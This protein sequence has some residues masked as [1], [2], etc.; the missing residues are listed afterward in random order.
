MEFRPFRELPPLSCVVSRNRTAV[1]E[2]QKS[3]A[4]RGF[5]AGAP[6]FTTALL[7][8][9]TKIERPKP[10]RSRPQRGGFPARRAPWPAL[11]LKPAHRAHT[12]PTTRSQLGQ[13]GGL[14]WL[15]C[16]RQIPGPEI[17]Q[18][19]AVLFQAV[20]IH[21]LRQRGPL[22]FRQ[23]I[24]EGELLAVRTGQN[25][26]QGGAQMAGVQAVG[27]VHTGSIIAACRNHAGTTVAH[28]GQPLS[29]HIAIVAYCVQC[30]CPQNNHMRGQHWP[31]I[32]EYKFCIQAL[33]QL[34]CRTEA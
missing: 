1:P 15:L 27:G 25:D 32:H 31:S 11:H 14:V 6:G 24:P 7:Y 2:P 20:G 12:G 30:A 17:R 18:R 5:V 4:L 22:R 29:A 26:I 10:G 33:Q 21:L 3:P 34:H 28:H 16:L 19:H 8:P 9:S 23:W 13:A